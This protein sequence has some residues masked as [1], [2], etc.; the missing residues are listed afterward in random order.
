MH[1]RCWSTWNV[2][3]TYLYAG[4]HLA[5]NP[6]QLVGRPKLAKLLPKALPRTAV[7]ALL[8]TVAH[9]QGS[10]RQTHWAERDL[11]LILTALQAGLPAEE[12]PHAGPGDIRTTADG[13]AGIP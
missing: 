6:M 3:C 4:E 7:E 8:E 9:D 12:L 10:Q 5:A 13:A 1:R 2:L 11:A